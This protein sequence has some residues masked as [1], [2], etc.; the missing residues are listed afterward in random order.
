MSGLPAGIRRV[1][2][3][4]DGLLMDQQNLPVGWTSNGIDRFVAIVET[5]PVTGGSSFSGATSTL[6]LAEGI[7]DLTAGVTG[8]AIG[9]VIGGATSG[10]I[11]F[12]GPG[13]VLAQ[14][15]ANLF[16][17]STSKQL[18]VGGPSI[19]IGKQG[20]QTGSLLLCHADTIDSLPNAHFG[21]FV[22]AHEWTNNPTYGNYID[23]VG[24]FGW[25]MTAQQAGEPGM[26]MS[27]ETRYT[28][29]DNQ[30]FFM[31]LHLVANGT[32]MWSS[33]VSRDT[34]LAQNQIAGQLQLTDSDTSGLNKIRFRFYE[35]GGCNFWEGVTGANN[36]VFT[37][38]GHGYNVANTGKTAIRITPSDGSYPM[39]GWL[40][41]G[42]Q[43]AAIFVDFTAGG[44]A[45]A[46]S[47]YMAISN[48]GAQFRMRG[49]RL[50]IENGSI[51]TS[52]P[53]GGTAAAWKLGVAAAI[54]PTAPNRTVELNVDGTTLYLA[55]KT[56]NN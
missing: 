45:P 43:K 33:Y 4:A 35:G 39:I 26:G 21:I 17:N 52:A 13:G 42:A 6:K 14:D 8:A 24:G 11:L 55:A 16:W 15:N 56:T 23:N 41:S 50:V 31:E 1:Y 12:A 46:G 10:S 25:N 37:F 18:F 9:A 29:G 28:Q 30:P 7:T 49:G 51:M 48:A 2:S 27:L 20:V 40:Q 5:D 3:D 19:T 47:M 36:N 38:N 54:S 44:D 34:G 22:E 53:T 32:R